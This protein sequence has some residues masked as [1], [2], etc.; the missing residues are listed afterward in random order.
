M[1]AVEVMLYTA[2]AMSAASAPSSGVM[3]SVAEKLQ[4]AVAGQDASCG[5]VCAH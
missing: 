5:E 4:L 3:A 1:A 2:R